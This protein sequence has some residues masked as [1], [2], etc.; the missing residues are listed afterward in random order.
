M[1]SRLYFIVAWT[2]FNVWISCHS[3]SADDDPSW[4]KY[5]R[6]PSSRFIT[7]KAVLTGYTVG[8]VTNVEGLVTGESVAHLTRARNASSDDVPTIV[9]D[10][11][12]DVVGLLRIAFAGSEGFDRGYP[13]LRLIF[14]ETKEFLTDRS[15]FTR[16]DH[17]ENDLRIVNGSDQIAVKSK[18]YEWLNQWGCEHDGQV[19]SDGLHGFRYVKIVMD[20]LPKDAPHTT[21]YGHVAISSVS[22]EWSGYLGTPDTYTGWFECSDANLTQWWYNA[23]YTTE[24]CT[25]VFRVNDTE[26]RHAASESLIGKMVIH[27]GPKR[28]RDPYMGDLAV[29]A[30]TSYLTHDIG[31][32]ARNVMED[33]AQHQRSDG[34]IPPASINNYTLNLFDYP[35]WW[36]SCSWDYVLYTGNVSYIEAYYPTLLKVLDAYYPANIDKST[37]LLLRPVDYGD[38]AFIPREGSAAY[39]SALYVLA[40][41]RAAELASILNRPDDASRW[42]NRSATVSKS[43]VDVLWDPTVKAFFDRNCKGNGCAA[44][45]QDGNSLAI[46]A[47][48]VPLSSNTSSAASDILDYLDKALHQ[49]YG[50][51]FYDAGG[52][53]LRP[54]YS[55]LVYPFISY[56]E[57]AARFR[58]GKTDSALNQVRRMYGWMASQDPGVTFW[59]GI[60]ASGEPYEADF[61][62]I[63]PATP[64]FL[65]WGVKP[66]VGDLTWAKG[67]VLTAR[68]PMQVSWSFDVEEDRVHVD[69]DAPAGTT[70]TV[71]VPS[72]GT[73]DGSGG[74]QTEI[75]L[76]GQVV[77]GGGAKV[78]TN[79]VTHRDEEGLIIVKVQGGMRHVLEF[80]KVNLYDAVDFGTDL[81]HTFIWPAFVVVL[82]TSVPIGNPVRKQKGNG[83]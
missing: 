24:M 35:L 41:D 12:Q 27:D 22:L 54:G 55:H 23:A 68:G 2:L 81:G 47:G 75:V 19:C 1:L 53:G 48:I 72:A 25:D 63:T 38:Y 40:L 51:T 34:W 50:N 73:D 39:Y 78:M 8:N 11:G 32:A 36:V 26:P 56:F 65:T 46:L 14:S 9:L 67:Q 58:V 76:D 31:E 16:S 5:V 21:S 3:A 20:A 18:P 10:F 57:I 70:G 6:A 49:R 17:G 52:N 29:S 60:G 83:Y 30:L 15:D 71:S 13:G 69:V 80:R 66:V 61:T 62:S 82:P 28:D 43:F 59:E 44:H 79:G 74:R 45:A 77:Y 7:P 42:R 4:H 33:L 64:G 37:S